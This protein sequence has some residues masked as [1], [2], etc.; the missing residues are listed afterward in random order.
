MRSGM[1][2]I[3]SRSAIPCFFFASSNVGV[4]ESRHPSFDA[5]PFQTN[6][7]PSFK[8]RPF[9]TFKEYLRLFGVSNVQEFWPERYLFDICAGALAKAAQS[10]ARPKWC[11]VGWTVSPLVDDCVI[12]LFFSPFKE[13]RQ[14]KKYPKKY[15]TDQST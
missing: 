10:G 3:S 8:R 5:N 13:K 11:R 9:C 12:C 14:A 4:T 2:A 1:V 7:S 15:L 6:R